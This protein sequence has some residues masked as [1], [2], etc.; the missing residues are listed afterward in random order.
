[1]SR[2]ETIQQMMKETA[3]AAYAVNPKADI[4][5]AMRKGHEIFYLADTLIKQFQ[6]ERE[7]KAREE[8]DKL[9]AEA[10]AQAEQRELEEAQ[11]I[12]DANKGKK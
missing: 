4:K 8:K 5:A 1:M 12:V 7:A 11:R 6:D 10:Q 9:D 3:I 2:R